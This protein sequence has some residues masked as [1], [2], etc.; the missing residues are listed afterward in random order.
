MFTKLCNILNKNKKKEIKNV[1]E[2]KVIALVC[3]VKKLENYI[4]RLVIIPVKSNHPE[5]KKDEGTEIEI[6]VTR[7]MKVLEHNIG[8]ITL[9][10]N[11][12]LKFINVY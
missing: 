3:S 12:D 4:Y 11:E 6:K 5:Y 2:I 9:I 1:N 7:P 10:F 8:I